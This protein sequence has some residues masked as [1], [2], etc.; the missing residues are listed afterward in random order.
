[1]QLMMEVDR[2][3]RELERSIPDFPAGKCKEAVAKMEE[4]GFERVDT[5]YTPRGGFPIGHV[6]GLHRGL[7]V[8][9]DITADQFPDEDK[10]IVAFWKNSPDTRYGVSYQKH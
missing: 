6:I 10:T 9:V 3:R 8:Y 7:G 1:M 4:L 5:I 2:V